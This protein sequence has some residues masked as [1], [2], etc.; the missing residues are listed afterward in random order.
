MAKRKSSGS[1][2]LLV[3]TAKGGFVFA[4]DAAR[5]TW[6]LH[7]PFLLGQKVHD[8]R[9]D[10]RPGGRRRAGRSIAEPLRRA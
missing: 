3:G 8:V 5:K 9:A 1:R 6:T 4:G 10:P 2:V 7:G